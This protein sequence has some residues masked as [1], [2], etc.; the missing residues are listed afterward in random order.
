MRPM[1]EIG[2]RHMKVMVGVKRVIDYAVKIRVKPDGS[3]VET[4]NVKMSMNPFDEIGG[5]H[6]ATQLANRR[7]ALGAA[8]NFKTCSP[9]PAR[10][11]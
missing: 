11:C 2:R 7:A 4:N 8:L 3:G 9:T 6:P 5:R 1:S 10:S